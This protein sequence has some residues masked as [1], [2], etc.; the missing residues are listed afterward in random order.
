MT[1]ALI[2]NKPSRKP[3]LPSKSSALLREKFKQFF[4]IISFL[5]GGTLIL[6]LISYDPTDPSFRSATSSSANNM[7]GSF[8]SYLADP[9]HLAIGLSSYGLSF[10]FFAWAWRFTFKKS[11]QNFIQR[12]IF[13]PIAIAALSMF[14][15]A[16]P[17]VDGWTF[18]Y[19]LG[20][21]FGD[22]ALS[23]IIGINILE[24]N[25]WLKIST[26]M[27][28]I[29]TISLSCIFFKKNLK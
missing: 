22:N 21:V 10:I 24:I 23:L 18:S 11:T 27:L 7:F 25:R 13:A 16:H 1:M 12:I 28:A 6:I 2:P 14:L 4:G 5:L 19:G 20:G 17:T 29:S 26:I 15:S 8:G 3:L 9:L